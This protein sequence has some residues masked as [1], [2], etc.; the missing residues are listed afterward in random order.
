MKS[1]TP[2]I[3]TGALSTR[4]APSYRTTVAPRSPFTP[5]YTRSAPSTVPSVGAKIATLGPRTR[6]VRASAARSAGVR[7]GATTTVSGAAARTVSAVT[8]ATTGAAASGSAWAPAPSPA[9]RTTGRTGLWT[10]ARIIKTVR[11]R[12][13]RIVA[14]SRRSDAQAT[15]RISLP[16][17]AGGIGIASLSIQL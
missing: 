1:M 4:A 6:D 16:G 15:M 17:R 9:A 11:W 12:C 8:A 5:T 2:S 7:A 14:E 3:R 10:A 13:N